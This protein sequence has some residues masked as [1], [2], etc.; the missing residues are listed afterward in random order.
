MTFVVSRTDRF[1]YFQA[2]LDLPDWRDKDVLDFGGSDGGLLR[3]PRNTI[4]TSRYWC[5]DIVQEAIARG[6]AAFPNAHWLLYDRY[7]FYYN[8]RGVPDLAIPDP[9]P[10][11]DII[12]AY[13]VFTSTRPAEMVTLVRQLEAL[14][15][16]DGRLA[17][18]FIDPH[19]HSWPDTNAGSNLQWRLEKERSEGAA[20]D[21]SGLLTRAAGAAYCILLNNTDL[22]VDDGVVPEYPLPAQKTSHVYYTA[23]RMA[24]IFPEATIRC[25]PDG[26]MQHCCIIRRR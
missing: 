6:Q 16:P 12:A 21:V 4:D 23:E 22:Y 3:D 8:P 9:G 26:E 19:Y 5:M 17:F 10:R 14:L 25:P 13:S 15:A 18:T 7:S 24:A 2:Q 1:G 20:I 11:F